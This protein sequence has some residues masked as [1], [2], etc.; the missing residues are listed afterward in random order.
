[1]GISIK[2][3]CA[4]NALGEPGPGTTSKYEVPHS[5]APINELSV[6]STL[7]IQV[8]S[9]NQGSASI[10]AADAPLRSASSN[11]ID[12]AL[13]GTDIPPW[14]P[15]THSRGPP[16]PELMETQTHNE[17]LTT[18]FIDAS[19]HHRKDSG[20]QNC[21]SDAIMDAAHGPPLSVGAK[22]A[23]LVLRVND[24]SVSSR[25]LPK[26]QITCY[27]ML[28]GMVD[29]QKLVHSS[30]LHNPTPAGDEN[31]SLIFTTGKA[32]TMAAPFIRF[33]LE[34]VAMVQTHRSE[35]NSLIILSFHP[36]ECIGKVSVCLLIPQ[37]IGAKFVCE[38]STRILNPVLVSFEA[39][40]LVRTHMSEQKLIN[41]S[42]F[43]DST[44]LR[45]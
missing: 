42:L 1:M 19:T 44:L 29:H 11:V 12:A 13:P 43:C 28:N 20:H 7:F 2:Q 27:D 17:F 39:S 15:P 35:Q 25:V 30:C 22:C 40:A 38:Y 8:S 21:G 34:T 3:P 4:P 23:S 10:P 41:F 18:L 32:S 9:L 33:H 26:H 36:I 37:L 45:V 31:Y 5:N 6:N 16:T 14:P 24:T